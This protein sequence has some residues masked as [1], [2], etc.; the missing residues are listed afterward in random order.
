MFIFSQLLCRV[1][2]CLRLKFQTEKQIL[3]Q[4]ETLSTDVKGHLGEQIKAIDAHVTQHVSTINDIRDFLKRKAEMDAEYAKKLEKLTDQY[5]VKLNNHLSEGKKPKDVRASR[6]FSGFQDCFVSLLNISK[7][8]CSDMSNDSYLANSFITDHISK[9]AINLRQAHDKNRLALLKCQEDFHN[10]VGQL[11]ANTKAYHLSSTDYRRENAKFEQASQELDKV[12]AA[13]EPKG[14]MA[15]KRLAAAENKRLNYQMS[16]NEKYANFNLRRNEYIMEIES[17][18]NLIDHIYSKIAPQV[19]ETSFLGHFNW[20]KHIFG[21]IC[22]VQEEMANRKLEKVHEFQ[23]LLLD[24][25]GTDE[26]RKI[27][28][29]HSKVFVPKSHFKFEFTPHATKNFKDDISNICLDLDLNECIETIKSSIKECEDTIIEKEQQI[30]FNRETFLNQIDKLFLDNKTILDSFTC[31]R[32]KSMSKFSDKFDESLA[33]FLDIQNQ[34]L[35]LVAGKVPEENKLACLLGRKTPVEETFGKT[36]KLNL[37]SYSNAARTATR[38]KSMLRPNFCVRPKSKIIA[39]L[40]GGKIDTYCFAAQIDIPPVVTS[41]INKIASSSDGREHSGIF[42]MNGLQSEVTNLKNMFNQSDNPIEDEPDRDW[43][44]NNI[45]ALLKMYFRELEEPL[46]PNSEFLELIRILHERPTS[47]SRFMTSLTSF[48]VELNVHVMITMRYLFDFLKYLTRFSEVNKMTEH[49]M[50]ICWGPTLMPIPADQ[51]Q[52]VY[53][54]D[55]TE[56]IHVFIEQTHQIFPRNYGTVFTVDDDDDDDAQSGNNTTIDTDDQFDETNSTNDFDDN[57]D[58]MYDAS[59]SNISL[60]SPSSQELIQSPNLPPTAESSES[61]EFLDLSQ[62]APARTS[63]ITTP[64]SPEVTE[65]SGTSRTMSAR[66]TS[67]CIGTIGSSTGS[68]SREQSPLLARKDDIVK[69]AEILNEGS[70]P[71][72]PL[73]R[74]PRIQR[75]ILKEVPDR[76]TPDGMT[77]PSEPVAALRSPKPLLQEVANKPIIYVPERAPPKS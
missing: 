70:P 74:S 28:D 51:N 1:L 31:N 68:M 7:Q 40:F 73:P 46:F 30:N 63:P 71:P 53:Q 75:G 47:E 9:V 48:V 52:V 77:S 27:M 69:S 62:N 55:V 57:D 38:S 3:T 4:I 36:I 65:H 24:L 35:R 12:K 33:K 60:T 2:I 41:C 67:V 20:F 56:I 18:N 76:S 25:S 15:K 45:A 26:V 23:S 66:A 17:V 8:T 32:E 42:R 13:G 37:E 22:L 50:A 29:D 59:S 44:W 11:T 34:D 72:Q 5:F 10:S 61:G 64:G 58:S 16:R 39:P 43:G 21:S 49:N 14:K 6:H 54:Q 19:L